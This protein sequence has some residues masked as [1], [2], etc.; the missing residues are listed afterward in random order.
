MN[1]DIKKTYFGSL[2]L[3]Y[4]CFYL[5]YKL[6]YLDKHDLV[7]NYLQQIVKVAK[8]KEK[9]LIEYRKLDASSARFITLNQ[10]IT[11]DREVLS[12]DAQEF[13]LYRTDFLVNKRIQTS[14]ELQEKYSPYP[15]Q[16]RVPARQFKIE[17]DHIVEKEFTSVSF[18]QLHTWQKRIQTDKNVHHYP[19]AKP[20]QIHFFGELKEGRD[21]HLNI[22]FYFFLIS[23][24][25]S[26]LLH[27]FDL[28][29]IRSVPIT[30]KKVSFDDI[31]YYYNEPFS[32]TFP[33]GKYAVP[34]DKYI[35]DPKQE[36][37]AMHYQWVFPEKKSD[38]VKIY[39][40]LEPDWN[41]LTPAEKFLYS[42]IELFKP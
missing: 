24:N 12:E 29:F 19:V 39:D 13:T 14:L 2:H 28:F 8:A 5:S 38:Q 22:L 40:P 27:A 36:M 31:V 33:K 17:N 25:V 34:N 18:K 15:F 21:C 7:D 10:H 16:F 32:V 42:D 9:W 4:L 3:E 23:S 11:P 37:R 1:N 30:I 20:F 35:F 26:N 6:E 41:N